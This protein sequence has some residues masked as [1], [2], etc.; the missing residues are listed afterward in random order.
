MNKNELLSGAAIIF[1]ELFKN[2]AFRDEGNEWG[3]VCSD[4]GNDI[5]S[6]EFRPDEHYDNCTWLMAQS[7]R[8]HFAALEKDEPGT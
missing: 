6:G 3:F 5:S 4:C 8:K 2:E 7:W 1:E